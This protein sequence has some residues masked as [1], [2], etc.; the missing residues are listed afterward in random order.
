MA[1]KVALA[2]NDTTNVPYF[3]FVQEA[4]SG[5]VVDLNGQVPGSK[6]TLLQIACYCGMPAGVEDPEMAARLDDELRNLD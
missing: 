1:V 5:F 3:G 6:E 4:N 2:F